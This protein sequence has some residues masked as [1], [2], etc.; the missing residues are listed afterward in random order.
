MSNQTTNIQYPL[1][2]D[3]MFG[4][5]MQNQVL[6]KDLLER[7]LPGRKIQELKVCDA[8]NTNLQKTII[9]GIISKCVRLDVL[10]TDDPDWY[11]LEMQNV[12][13]PYLPMRGRYYGAAMDIDQINKGSHYY[14]LKNNYVIFICTFDYY[15]RG[16]AI[17]HFQNYDCK[18]NL[19][20][21]DNSRKIIVNTRSPK[22]NTPPELVPFFDYVNNMK[23]PEDDTF[24]KALH[25]QVEKYNTSDWRRRLMTLEE[26]LRI[27]KDMAFAEGEAKGEEKA[28]LEDAKKMK[29]EGIDIEIIC[30]IT[31]FSA[32]KIGKL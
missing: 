31:G 14:Q 7:I 25:K 6:C 21:G 23:V 32:E 9:T 10:F 16:Q 30:R 8:S 17:Y 15:N 5:V 28:K 18:N 26:Q 12:S 11:N 1:N 19:P 4:L 2:N 20:Y 3:L 24:I 27:E 13:D 29:A 22:E